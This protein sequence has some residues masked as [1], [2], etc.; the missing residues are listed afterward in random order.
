VPY[1]RTLIACSIVVNGVDLR[2][3]FGFE[4]LQVGNRESLTF[5]RRTLQTPLR[6]GVISHGGRYSPSTITVSGWMPKTGLSGL[7]RLLVTDTAIPNYARRGRYIQF[8]D[9]PTKV[10]IFDTVKAFAESP[11]TNRWVRNDEVNV[12]FSIEVTDALGSLMRPGHYGLSNETMELGEVEDD[13]VVLKS[14]DLDAALSWGR[15]SLR[16]FVPSSEIVAPAVHGVDRAIVATFDRAI[17]YRDYTGLE[18]SG[19][20]KCATNLLS[21][22]YFNGGS[23]VGWTASGCSMT[24]V[25]NVRFSASRS[26]R[27][28]YGVGCLYVSGA[29]AGDTIRSTFA[30]VSGEEYVVRLAVCLPYGGD[31]TLTARI[32]NAGGTAVISK[33]ITGTYG[34]WIYEEFVFKADASATWALEF[35]NAGTQTDYW[36]GRAVVSTSL[37]TNGA[38]D[39]TTTDWSATNATRAVEATT[40]RTGANALS[41]D[42]TSAYGYASYGTRTFTDGEVYYL[43]GYARRVSGTG[44]LLIGVV[45]ATDI[46]ILAGAQLVTG[47]WVRFSACYVA[48]TT[49]AVPFS[50]ASDD[51]GTLVIFDDVSLVALDQDQDPYF[52]PGVYGSRLQV[53]IGE[54]VRIDS[55]RN[56][57]NGRSLTIHAQ[58]SPMQFQGA[59]AGVVVL[60]GLNATSVVAL[61]RDA[62][63]GGMGLANGGTGVSGIGATKAAAL[64]MDDLGVPPRGTHGMALRYDRLGLV[65]GGALRMAVERPMDDTPG[66]VS[67]AQALEAAGTAP[68]SEIDEAF[69][70]LLL[71]D[72]VA[73]DALWIT[74]YAQSDELLLAEMMAV[75]VPPNRSVGVAGSDAGEYMIDLDRYLFEFYDVGDSAWENAWTGA[76][77]DLP[78]F[79]GE[80]AVLYVR[81]KV[82]ILQAMARRAP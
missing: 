78:R 64:T 75:D 70:V 54:V 65:A 41:V 6:H 31:T 61:C 56:I 66:E 76:L 45:A 5:E 44:D 23:T 50:L 73:W 51:D 13:F 36:I 14:A 59:G 62:T 77:G 9:M 37:L 11:R 55:F 21:N 39:G 8:S 74:P 49:S 16:Y 38:N 81:G 7:R 79:Y 47:E 80:H 53:P 19:T 46:T 17:K 4:G 12:T 25:Q 28:L 29:G 35:E 26:L 58:V 3:A 40:V 60:A 57:V 34:E 69:D 10:F 33:A 32:E 42:Y 82:T 71:G 24:V 72:G 20:L 27:C 2:Q 30:V 22:G 18:A 67:L 52:E 63:K 1:D 68:A 15:A 43:S 48:K